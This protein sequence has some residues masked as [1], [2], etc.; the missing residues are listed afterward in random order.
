MSGNVVVPPQHRQQQLPSTGA[1]QHSW[2]H[3]GQHHTAFSPGHVIAHSSP[4]PLLGAAAAVNGDAAV[5]GQAAVQQQE[6]DGSEYYE[7]SSSGSAVG[8]GG[9]VCY[10]GT[11]NRSMWCGQSTATA[12]EEADDWAPAP[13]GSGVTAA[14]VAAAVAAAVGVRQH[15]PHAG[16]SSSGRDNRAQAAA[17]ATGASTAGAA[18]GTAAE[19]AQP[20]AGAQAAPAVSAGPP[21]PAND[22]SPTPSSKLA[23]LS[24]SARNFLRPG[25]NPS[26]AAAAATSGAGAAGAGAGTGQLPLLL[27][28]AAAGALHQGVVG[29]SDVLPQQQHVAQHGPNPANRPTGQHQEPQHDVQA[30]ERVE[31]AAQATRQVHFDPAVAAPTVAAAAMEGAVVQGADAPLRT[32]PPE[33]SASGGSHS[34]T[35]YSS[36]SSSAPHSSSVTEQDSSSDDEQPEEQQQPKLTETE[37]AIAA[38]MSLKASL[39]KQAF[40]GGIARQRS[41]TAAVAANRLSVDAGLA[42]AGAHSAA[43]PAAAVARHSFDVATARAY[44]NPA[45]GP[46]MLR[47]HS[48]YALAVPPPFLAP[49]VGAGFG[50]RGLLPQQQLWAGAAGPHPAAGREGMA[51]R[52]MSWSG[53]LS[54][55]AGRGATQARPPPSPIPGVPRGVAGTSAPL[56]HVGPLPL[57]LVH[58]Q[59]SALEVHFGTAAAAAG[60][61]RSLGVQDGA[62]QR[63]AADAQAAAAAHVPVQDGSS[64]APAA[65]RSWHTGLANL[66][67]HLLQPAFSGGPR[68]PQHQQHPH[69]QPQLQLAPQQQQQQRVPPRWSP[70]TSWK[71]P[72]RK[73]VSASQLG[74]NRTTSFFANPTPAA[75]PAAAG[76]L[77]GVAALLNNAP[78][79]PLPP[80]L[81]EESTLTMGTSAPSSAQ[82]AGVISPDTA[83]AGVTAA[84]RASA[85]HLM[86]LQ[87]QRSSLQL[88]LLSSLQQGGAA[89]GPQQLGLAGLD[90]AQLQLLAQIAD[91]ARAQ[92]SPLS[93]VGDP[94][95]DQQ[96]LGGDSLV[97]QQRWRSAPSA[98]TPSSDSPLQQQGPHTS[99]PRP[100]HTASFNQPGVRQYGTSAAAVAAAQAAAAACST[101][102]GVA[103]PAG[104][105]GPG[106]QHRTS[107]GGRPRRS[108]APVLSQQQQQLYKQQ[109][110]AL[111]QHMQQH[112]Q[113]Q[114]QRG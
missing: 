5:A 7:E 44:A 9:A 17:A 82:A 46:D 54:P 15:G 106:G 63:G 3:F 91:A 98:G 71:P 42:A 21:A 108:S 80:V 29:L 10:R 97:T 96:K 109:V 22:T 31:P 77:P 85:Q 76:V 113:Q 72:V 78:S 35:V 73:T 2:P 41:A 40:A 27:Q 90:P 48:A 8:R 102:R 18:A 66:A 67:S 59:L 65:R 111:Q 13:A 6:P 11:K 4:L 50:H 36:G 79:Q 64:P 103:T 110:A 23:R 100:Q 83:A 25:S 20:A 56:Q 53:P 84:A 88:P 34:V 86:Q 14:G 89:G 101:P 104:S 19:A 28:D 30:Y 93:V 105:P 51:Q 55:A 68:S 74:A 112:M 62:R 43:P 69:A 94:L 47:A 75:T 92:V 49:G 45:T 60:D 70:R 52:G 107:P 39:A 61:S 87:Q 114:Q 26:G 24:Q 37:A 58:Q 1:A 32:W 38:V 12:S 99:R 95:G 81:A 16:D 33:P 57:H